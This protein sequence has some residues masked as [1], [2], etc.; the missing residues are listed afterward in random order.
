MLFRVLNLKKNKMNIK[1]LYQIEQ[2][3]YLKKQLEQKIKKKKYNKFSVKYF[4]A[5]KRNQC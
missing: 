5:L 4:K 2:I 3:M 1:S